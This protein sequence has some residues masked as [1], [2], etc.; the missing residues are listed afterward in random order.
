MTRRSP[1]LVPANSWSVILSNISRIEGLRSMIS[2]VHAR[3]I[4][5]YGLVRY[6]RTR[7]ASSLDQRLRV[8]RTIFLRRV[9]VPCSNE[10]NIGVMGIRK[11]WETYAKR[12]SRCLKVAVAMVV[13]TINCIVRNNSGI[14]PSI[15]MR[16][17]DIVIDNVSSGALYATSGAHISM[18]V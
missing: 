2:L 10:P 6:G 4:R 3:V 9:L 14:S 8:Q 15:G 16:G 17:L 18:I 5:R 1:G 7:I 13:D 11:A 12:S